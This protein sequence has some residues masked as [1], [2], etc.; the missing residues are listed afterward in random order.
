M[1]HIATAMHRSLRRGVGEIILNSL[2]GKRTIT[3]EVDSVKNTFSS[4]DNC[5][6]KGYCKSVSERSLSP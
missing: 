5:M 6:A 3:G 4:W 2:V 1:P